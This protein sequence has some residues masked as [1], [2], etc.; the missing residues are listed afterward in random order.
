M[1]M[2]LTVGIDPDGKPPRTGCIG[3]IRLGRDAVWSAVSNLVFLGSLP[4]DDFARLVSADAQW[5]G[6]N[7]YMGLAPFWHPDYHRLLK[8]L[9]P[10][11]LR[12][13]HADLLRM[14]GPDEVA[15]TSL[16]HEYVFA[17]HVR[18]RQYADTREVLNLDVLSDRARQLLRATLHASETR[19]ERLEADSAG[20]ADRPFGT[21]HTQAGGHRRGGPSWVGRSLGDICRN[22]ERAVRPLRP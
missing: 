19:H 2:R 18:G 21:A 9:P 3:C 17:S 4:P 12:R 5:I 20:Q 10:R 16:L 14:L 11:R 15:A 13:I 8:E 1:Q 7:D 6:T 22:G